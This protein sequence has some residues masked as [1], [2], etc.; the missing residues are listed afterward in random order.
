MILSLARV[1]N[2]QQPA[3]AVESDEVPACGIVTVV[4]WRIVSQV[5]IIMITWCN[6][7]LIFVI[8]NDRV[9]DR[10]ETSI[11]CACLAVPIV[12]LSRCAFLINIP[13]IKNRLGFQELMRLVT[14]PEFVA[15][16][17]PSPALTSVNGCPAGGV[18]PVV[19]A[20]VLLGAGGVVTPLFNVIVIEEGFEVLPSFIK[21]TTWST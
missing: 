14:L 6:A 11:K 4:C 9:S 1:A 5:P 10:F 20:K 7:I 19:G 21:A 12:E 15:P 18:V 16:S 17:A 2:M 8:A 13:N 3:V